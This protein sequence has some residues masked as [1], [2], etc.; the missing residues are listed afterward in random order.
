MFLR[1][2]DTKTGMAVLK[3]A[4]GSGNRKRRPV[5]RPAWF[6]SFSVRTTV[7]RRRITKS[8]RLAVLPLFVGSAFYSSVEALP[9][10]TI[11]PDSIDGAEFSGKPPPVSKISPLSVRLQVLLARAHFSPGE[12]D[13]KFGENVKKALRAY[14]EAHQLKDGGLT[15]EI[16]HGLVADD[17]PILT[18][19]RVTEKDVAGP[20]LSRLPRRMED[21]KSIPRL[22]YISPREELAERFHMSEE[23]LA[24]LNPGDDF[25]KA[26]ATLAVIDLGNTDRTSAAKA[27]HVEVNKVDQTVEVFDASNHLIDFYPATVGSEEKPSP[28]GTLK[29]T[30]VDQNP[31]YRYNPKY[32]FKGVRS[33]SPFVIRPGPNNPVGTVWINLSAEGYGI[34]GTPDPGKISKA[35]SHGCVR[36]TNWDAETTAA[37]VR[38][39]TPVVFVDRHE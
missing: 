25:R 9:A 23:L 29:V 15:Q 13:G 34:H 5:E 2:R 37:E 10:A 35:Q 18:T 20:F 7:S 14:A 39:G 6:T 4:A 36:L 24:A 19:Y 32:H 17:R 12:I 30:S 31:T 21:M 16:W 38:K 22:D 33:K 3:A 11:K 28:S 8:F 26:G 1:N 27:D